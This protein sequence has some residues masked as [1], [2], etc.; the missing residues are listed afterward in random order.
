[1]RVSVKPNQLF[2]F[3]LN[4]ELKV[5]F[6]FIYTDFGARYRLLCLKEGQAS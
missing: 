4:V 3:G 2:S 5:L 1:M 6:I